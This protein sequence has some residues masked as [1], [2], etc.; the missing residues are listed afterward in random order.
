MKWHAGQLVRTSEFNAAFAT[1]VITSILPASGVAAG[2]TVVTIRGTD[3]NVV[4]AVTFAGAAGTALSVTKT[5]IKVTTPA[6]AVGAV[7]V[8]L[9]ND[10]GT[11]VTSAGGFTYV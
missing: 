3:L 9:T 2:G 10:T 1:P 6:H 7:A 11:D 4:T 5:A 8:A